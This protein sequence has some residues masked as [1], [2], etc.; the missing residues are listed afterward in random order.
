MALLSPSAQAAGT[1][2]VTMYTN[3]DA[4]KFVSSSTGMQYSS[5]DCMSR[6]GALG[7]RYCI[8]ID[9]D[10]NA[11]LHSGS[12]KTQINGAYSSGAIL[13]TAMMIGNAVNIMEYAMIDTD[14]NLTLRNN[15]TTPEQT[16][17]MMSKHKYL[18]VESDGEGLIRN[19]TVDMLAI[20]TDNVAHWYQYQSSGY[21][22]DRTDDQNFSQVTASGKWARG[23]IAF[24]HYSQTD[25]ASTTTAAMWLIDTA[26][27]VS[28]FTYTAAGGWQQA[29][30][31]K[32]LNGKTIRQVSAISWEWR[33]G[34]FVSVAMLIDA[35]G[36]LV[37]STLP[38]EAFT[39]F[40]VADSTYP[41][42]TACKEAHMDEDVALCK[43]YEGRYRDVAFVDDSAGG[44]GSNGPN[45]WNSYYLINGIPDPLPT[46]SHTL[47]FDLGDAPGEAPAPQSLAAGKVTVQPDDPKWGG[48]TFDGWYT[49]KTGGDKFVFGQALDGDVTVYA[50]WGETNTGTTIAC[51]PQTGVDPAVSLWQVSAV[52]LGLVS[53]VLAGV[54]LR[55]GRRL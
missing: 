45:S 24:S 31:P 11:Y 28:V 26:G 43:V 32:I 36:G 23:D 15:N 42:S 14:G 34:Q 5:V 20:D 39:R 25:G 16:P 50:H 21:W 38:E 41:N 2:A 52:L 13:T 12:S 49:A 33:G 44:S 54:V 37:T 53:F 10:G 18:D 8:G 47:T 4:G 27:K 7:G 46:G 9:G 19:N 35:D 30:A 22:S 29:A 40:A 55:F 17:S 6:G 48:H 3:N 51:A 1:G